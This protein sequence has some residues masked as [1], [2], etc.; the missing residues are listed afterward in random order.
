MTKNNNEHKTILLD[1]TENVQNLLS[2]AVKRTDD[3]RY[4]ESERINGRFIQESAHVRELMT[5]RAEYTEKLTVAE[6]KRIDAIRAVDVNAVSVASERA[7]Q[8]ASVL[9]TQVSASA[10]TL[11]A[12]VASS[13]TAT[14]AQLTQI[15][16]PITDRLALL[17]KAQYEGAGK[18]S[19]TDPQ[20]AQLI[21]EMQVTRDT[22]S[23]GTGKSLATATNWTQLGIIGGLLLGLLKLFKI[24]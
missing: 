13:A 6:A 4:A 16:T 10:E 1:P 14:A 18:G 9:A 8:Q 17:E 11:R 20:I 15:I 12:L 21:K 24:I 7:T 19:V 23:Q 3:L 2:E 22:L 5:L